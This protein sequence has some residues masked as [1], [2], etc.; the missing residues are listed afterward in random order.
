MNPYSSLSGK[1]ILITGGTSGIGLKTVE[2]LSEQKAILT[3]IGRNKDLLEK[4]QQTFPHSIKEIIVGDLSNLDDL[5]LSLKSISTVF[6][7]VVLSAGVASFL[8]IKFLKKEKSL[9]VFNVNFFSNTMILQYLVKNKLL[10]KNSSI[11][12]ISS[13]S[14]YVAEIG[15]SIYSASKAALAAF[16]RNLALELAPQKICVNTISPGL[17]QTNLL[18]DKQGIL[19]ESQL[20]KNT[21]EYPLG[22]GTPN[23]VAAMVLFLLN[24]DSQWITGSDFKMDGGF[25]LR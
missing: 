1:K 4:L 21:S 12:L 25:C 3:L 15:T 17:V 13:I 11:V 8:P 19:N 6:D 20:T 22:L 18:N 2:L 7:G 24:Q 10:S 16:S 23:D 14:Q 5:E 9:E